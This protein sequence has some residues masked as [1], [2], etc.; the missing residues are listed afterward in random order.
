MARKRHKHQQK[1]QNV[2][3]TPKKINV[4]GW[5]GG[6]RVSEVGRE[7]NTIKTTLAPVNVIR[8]STKHIWSKV[9]TNPFPYTHHWFK[10][11]ERRRSKSILKR[12]GLN[13]P[14][15]ST[16]QVG[17][18][19]NLSPHLLTNIISLKSLRAAQRNQRNYNRM[20][21]KRTRRSISWFR[22]GKDGVFMDSDREF[23]KDSQ[24]E[25]EPWMV[26]LFKSMHI[27]VCY[28]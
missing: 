6:F 19:H 20:F 10:N 3:K 25:D 2:L 18:R 12:K 9:R 11:L 27:N 28:R 5:V 24:I 7:I 15:Y 22:Q 23:V 16:Q 1:K 14:V 26:R 17:E 21:P 8:Q 13:F 4:D